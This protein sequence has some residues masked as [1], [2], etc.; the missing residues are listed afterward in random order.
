MF[1]GLTLVFQQ[2]HILVQVDDF[3]RSQT[4]EIY[5]DPLKNKSVSSVNVQPLSTQASTNMGI[6]FLYIFFP[7]SC[8]KV[9]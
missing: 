4:A 2:R 7:L 5:C 9:L 3:Y 1:L 8:L 6:Y